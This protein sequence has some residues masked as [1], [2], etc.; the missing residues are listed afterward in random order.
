MEG[1]VRICFEAVFAWVSLVDQMVKNPSVMWKTQV[2]FLGW[3][4]PLEKGM[5]AAP[6]FLPEEFHG[7]RSLVVYSP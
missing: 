6:V 1:R 3:E 4:D 7:Q 5:L 2:Q